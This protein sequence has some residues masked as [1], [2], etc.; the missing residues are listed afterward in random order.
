MVDEDGNFFFIPLLIGAAIGAYQGYKLG[1][2]QGAEG[3]GLAMMTLFGGSVGAFAG[4]AG[5]G[6]AGAGFVGAGTL[7]LATSSTVNSFGTTM[8]SNFKSDFSTNFGFGSMNWSKG[9][10]NVANPFEKGKNGF[11]RAMDIGGWLTVGSD[12]YKAPKQLRNMRLNAKYG[13]G[14][15]EIWDAADLAK[16]KTLGNQSFTGDGPNASLDEL[17]MFKNMDD[18]GVPGITKNRADYAAIIHDLKYVRAEAS[19]GAMSVIT[20]VNV[21][22]A[23]IELIGRNLV[24]IV[25]GQGS[26]F[27]SGFFLFSGAVYLKTMGEIGKYRYNY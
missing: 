26:F 6:I 9:E 22:P 7:G 24:N 15:S 18:A 13:K 4:V 12:L 2:A 21:L 14:T 8:L 25:T 23:D 11:E 19:G 27:D 20:D 3:M 17:E 1:K 16:R 10:F 5:A